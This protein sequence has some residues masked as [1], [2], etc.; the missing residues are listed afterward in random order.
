MYL[1]MR[2][3]FIH[4]KGRADEKFKIKYPELKLKGEDKLPTNFKTVI[5]AIKTIQNFTKAIDDQLSEQE[6]LQKK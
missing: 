5:A 2:H 6:Y 4:G 1:E 3:L